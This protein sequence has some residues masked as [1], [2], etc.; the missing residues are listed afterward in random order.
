MISQGQIFDTHGNI[1]FIPILPIE[2][3]LGWKGKGYDAIAML[4]VEA[5]EDVGQICTM[6]GMVHEGDTATDTEVEGGRELLAT[7]VKALAFSLF[8]EEPNTCMTENHMKLLRGFRGTVAQLG[9]KQVL[10]PT[11]RNPEET[12]PVL[13]LS[14]VAQGSSQGHPAP[15]P[16]LLLFKSAI[17]WAKKYQLEL[18]AGGAIPDLDEEISESSLMAE[19]AVLEAREC[20]EKQELQSR[21]VGMD[22]LVPRVETS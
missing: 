8:K 12:K 1:I 3:V 14:F 16:L 21:V 15:D 5:N 7:A 10:V 19:Q 18:L 6:I 2:D 11:S 4:G 22:I 20:F 17:N 13:K 9:E